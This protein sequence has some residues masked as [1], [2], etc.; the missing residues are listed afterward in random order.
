MKK[1]E[2][3]EYDIF[4]VEGVPV[5][6]LVKKNGKELSADEQK[7]ENEQIDKEVAKAK[8]K[9]AKADAK[10]KE[11]DPRGNELITVSRLLELGNFT[12]ARDG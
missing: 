6:R 1:T 10:G 9:R 3:R 7:K 8:E 2:T 4:W 5:Q 11:T 12:N